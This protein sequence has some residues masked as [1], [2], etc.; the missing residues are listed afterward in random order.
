MLGKK[1]GRWAAAQRRGHDRS[2][3]C[4]IDQGEQLKGEN[5]QG[6]GFSL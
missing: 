1:L 2:Y 5:E 4:M 6:S 3:R